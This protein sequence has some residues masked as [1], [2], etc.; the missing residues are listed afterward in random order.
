MQ[1]LFTV[2]TRHQYVCVCLFRCLHAHFNIFA[3]LT[4][5]IRLTQLSWADPR[6]IGGENRIR[7]FRKKARRVLMQ[8]SGFYLLIPALETQREL[9]THNGWCILIGLLQLKRAGQG[10]HEFLRAQVSKVGVK[11]KNK[12]SESDLSLHRRS[13]Y[14]LSAFFHCM[15]SWSS[16]KGLLTTYK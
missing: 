15:D 2:W 7:I 10:H 4:E 9:Q 3:H 11:N 6:K 12:D 8:S 1:Q 16:F 5:H 14:S 13:A